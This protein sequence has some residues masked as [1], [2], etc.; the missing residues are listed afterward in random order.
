M[1]RMASSVAIL[2][3]EEVLQAVNAYR[4]MMPEFL[5]RGPILGFRL[6]EPEAP[7]GTPALTVSVEMSYGRTQQVTELRAEG[8]DVVQMLVRCCVENNIPIPRR[9]AKRIT[10]DPSAPQSQVPPM[11]LSGHPRIAID[12]EMCGGRPTIA[13]TRVRVID[14]LEMLAGGATA[15][16]IAEDFPYLSQEDVRAA[17]AYAA[18]T[19]NH[20]VVL[21]AE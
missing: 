9:G 13:G 17:L 2:S 4:R 3:A 16:E 10:L 1:V 12:P 8:T 20:P 5:P 19:M 21:A 15:G 7:G 14:I 6:D 11:T 18:A